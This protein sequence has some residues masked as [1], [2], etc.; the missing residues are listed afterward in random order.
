MSANWIHNGM[1]IVHTTLWPLDARWL[2]AEPQARSEKK[3]R[4]SADNSAKP[5]H[6]NS[7][8]ANKPFKW[9]HHLDQDVGAAG[10][11]VVPDSRAQHG[12][13]RRRRVEVEAAPP[14][15]VMRPRQSLVGSIHALRDAAGDGRSGRP[16]GR[17]GPARMLHGALA[18][19]EGSS[20]TAA[21]RGSGWTG[22]ASSPHTSTPPPLPTHAH[23]L[24]TPL[25]PRYRD[26][27]G[28]IETTRMA[29]P[30]LLGWVVLA[31]CAGQGHIGRRGAE[32]GPG[33]ARTAA[34]G[35]PADGDAE[36]EPRAVGQ[37]A[38]LV[39]PDP[40]DGRARVRLRA[41]RRVGP[42]GG[43]RARLAG[44]AP[45]PRVTRSRKAVHAN[46]TH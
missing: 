23:P 1:T 17:A 24:P 20:R 33:S 38:A 7:N 10:R 30:C 31:G 32:A 34:G 27:E 40:D 45:R 14:R 13:P 29:Q 11:A 3:A 35:A 21:G 46:P 9:R 4:R 16:A 6:A 44:A 43:G 22:S 5:A 15:A 18:V 8:N 42:E 12:H 25:Q 37:D 26:W 41:G 28:G 36:V 19:G 2:T 39:G